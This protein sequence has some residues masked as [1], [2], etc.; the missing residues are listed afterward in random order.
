M[1][2]QVKDGPCG[3]VKMPRALTVDQI[4]A[5]KEVIFPAL[6]FFNLVYCKFVYEEL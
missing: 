2:I 4:A 1:K 3:E 6:P 5:N